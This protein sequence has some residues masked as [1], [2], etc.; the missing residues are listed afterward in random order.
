MD[1]E[2]D[3][4]EESVSDDRLNQQSSNTDDG[5]RVQSSVELFFG[6]SS[7]VLGLVLAVSGIP[8]YQRPI[9][10]QK[11]QNGEYI[12]SLTYNDLYDGQTVSGKFLD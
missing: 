9:P 7:L 12:F 10:A 4:H 2:A 5:N 6:F 11:L 1:E 8:P 3:V